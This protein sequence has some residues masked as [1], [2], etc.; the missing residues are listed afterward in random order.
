MNRSINAVVQLALLFSAPAVA[1]AQSAPQQAPAS[2]SYTTA[3]TEIGKLLDDAAAKAILDK[4]LPT[5]M[6]SGRADMARAMTLKSIQQYAPDMFTEK[7]LADID[8]ELAK[9]PAKK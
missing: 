4:H 5:F 8:V 6:G 1:L 3:T 9:L 7:A 2:A